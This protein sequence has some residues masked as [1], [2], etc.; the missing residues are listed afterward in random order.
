MTTKTMF[1]FEPN[2]TY[3]LSYDLAGSQRGDTNTVV[4]SLGSIYN[5]SFTLES[6]VPF[7]TTTH[8]FTV[9]GSTNAALSFDHDGGD[10][11]GIFLDNVSITSSTSSPE[12]IPEP[13]TM[14]LLG[15]GLV[16]LAG[17]GR[18]RFRRNS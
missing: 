9:Q 7:Q 15:T 17:M 10:C 4:V 8:C 1:S 6:S 11:Y 12:P 13:C 3:E 14:L 5:Q 2:Y 16:G 18:R